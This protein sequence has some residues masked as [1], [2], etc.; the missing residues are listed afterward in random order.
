MIVHTDLFASRYRLVR[1]I[2]QGGMSDVYRAVDERS[3]GL[4]AVKIVRS[5]DPEF[6]RRLAQEVRALQRIEDPG[7]VALL[8][9]GLEGDQAYLVMELVEGPT[10]AGT[11]RDGPLSPRNTAHLGAGLAGALTHVHAQGIVHRD[12][13]PSNILLG[14]D[15]RARLGDFGIA[16]LLDT[17]TFTL[18]GTTLGTAGYMAPEQL[19]DHEV[20]PS[21][22]VW[23][24]GIV[25]LECL[26]G[27]RVYE[28]TGSEIIARRLSGPV[29]LPV[30]LPVP[31]K[32][33]LS[34]MLDHRPGQ[35][36]H[37]AQVAALLATSA[38]GSPW[39]PASSAATDRLSSTAPLDLTA[40]VAPAAAAAAVV[41]PAVLDP[42]DTRVAAAAPWV[43]P[44]SDKVRHG[45]RRH[46]ALAAAALAVLLVAAGVL[47]GLHIGPSP[48][49]GPPSHRNT[50]STDPPTTTTTTPPT[51]TTTTALTASGALS[52]LVN[53]VT[54]GIEAGT[55]DSGVGQSIA[56][57]AQQAVTDEAAGSADQAA[58]DLQQAAMAI[59]DGVDQG[60]ISNAEET[61]LQNDLSILASTLGL[62]A[63]ATPPTTTTPGPGPSGPGNGNGGGP[64]HGNGQ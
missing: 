60:A 39:V 18:D 30:D 64:H 31:W 46:W 34:G 48:A 2:G 40:L 54:S 37:G 51:T 62:S 49:A 21:A 55:L 24:L 28:G 36:L 29:P 20:G 10:L 15:G 53:D 3:G 14:S 6:A 47:L 50:T 7:L 42:G 38:F 61:T 5:G 32:L 1:L 58:N 63:A 41:G 19:E 59:A 22:D 33:V 43:K 8:D 45:H 25:L 16:R 4:V 23:S 52:G 27:R 11:L 17:S 44:G 26:T 56:N 9:T 12:V 13:K 57:L 35:R